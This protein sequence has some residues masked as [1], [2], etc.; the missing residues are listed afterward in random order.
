[1]A[2]PPRPPPAP[3]PLQELLHRAGGGRRHAPTWGGGGG[4]KRGGGGGTFCSPLPPPTFSRFFFHPLPPFSLSYLNYKKGK[5]KDKKNKT[6]RGIKSGRCFLLRCRPLGLNGFR[7]GGAQPLKAAQNSLSHHAPR[8]R[9]ACRHHPAPQRTTGD[10][11]SAAPP[12]RARLPVTPRGRARKDDGSCIHAPSLR[13]SA[14][15][16]RLPMMPRGRAPPAANARRRKGRW[17]LWSVPLSQSELAAPLPDGRG[18]GF[19]PA[20]PRSAR[21]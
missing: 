6:P 8:L 1:M 9:L 19:T 13:I 21:P 20:P 16:S 17:E 14:N 11:V 18:R 2:P 4:R 10:V 12:I 5:K 7:S 3:Q 15:Q